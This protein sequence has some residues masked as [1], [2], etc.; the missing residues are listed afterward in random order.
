MTKAEEFANPAERL[1]FL[2]RAVSAAAQRLGVNYFNQCVGDFWG[3]LETRPYM[4]GKSKLAFA[5][6]ELGRA[7][8]AIAAW[9]ECLRLCDSD[10]LGIREVLTSI[11]LEKGNLDGA[12]AIVNKFAKQDCPIG[13]GF[14]RVLLLFKRAKAAAAALP[15]AASAGANAGASSASSGAG[16]AAGQPD[17]QRLLQQALAE[18][19]QALRS[20]V[21]V[22]DYLTGAKAVPQKL[23]EYI[24]CGGPNEAEE[25]V[26]WALRAWQQ[27]AGAL[28]W[29]QQ[30]V[31][32]VAG[33]ASNR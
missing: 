27:T 19:R 15:G 23:P 28:D 29:L 11:L 14:A 8:E 25:Y 3:I 17:S 4:R 16:A 30:N 24:T 5:L 13:M 7:N 26:R 6:W 31:R 18:L 33:V 20:N 1:P 10:N 32:L 21:Y 2:Q 9:T 22:V 12:E